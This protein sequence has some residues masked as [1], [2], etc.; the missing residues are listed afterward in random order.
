MK[1]KRRLY[2]QVM[3]KDSEKNVS[4]KKLW[5]WSKSFF[6]LRLVSLQS[7]WVFLCVKINKSSQTLREQILLS[8]IRTEP[9][10]CS[11][12]CDQITM[13][14]QSTF[15][16]AVES[17]TKVYVLVRECIWWQTVQLSVNLSI[18][19]CYGC[20]VLQLYQHI[21]PCASIRWEWSKRKRIERIWRL[22]V[23]KEYATNSHNTAKSWWRCSESSEIYMLQC[24]AFDLQV[25]HCDIV[26]VQLLISSRA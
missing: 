21:R 8:G 6:L 24:S 5:K 15:Y 17:S 18:P 11:T 22:K 1:I 9:F 13:T 19:I 4:L 3:Q 25:Y 7:N 2:L 26:V 16:F 23:E 12:L 20:L 14:H 10:H